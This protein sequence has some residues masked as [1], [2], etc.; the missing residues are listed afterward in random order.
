MSNRLLLLNKTVRATARN[1]FTTITCEDNDDPASDNIPTDQIVP[2]NTLENQFGFLCRVVEKSNIPVGTI[3]QYVGLEAPRGWL[4][5][6][7]NSYSRVEYNQLFCVIGIMYGNNDGNTFKVP[8]FRGRIGVGYGQGPALT[9]RNMGDISGEEFHQLTIAELP[10]HNHDISGNVGTFGY[11]SI[12]GSHDHTYTDPGHVHS[13]TLNNIDNRESEGVT[14][15][16]GSGA[17]VSGTASG[18]DGAPSV[19]INNN[20]IGITINPNGNHQH[21]ISSQGSDVP[22]NNMQPYVVVNYLIRW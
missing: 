15:A 1:P 16:F 17:Q 5:C 6:N 10:A 2:H 22:H 7:G 3:I 18:G 14:N 9:N 21:R 4:F 19:T 12:D 8:D 13:G 20:T 11:T